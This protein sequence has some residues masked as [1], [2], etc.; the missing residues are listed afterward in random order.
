MKLSW[1][2]L[3]EI[4]QK[5]VPQRDEARQDRSQLV[6][7][8][9]PDDLEDRAAADFRPHTIRCPESLDPATAP[10]T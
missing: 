9:D 3:H 10:M 6:P 4:L 5:P 1:P 2:G 8:L 7:A